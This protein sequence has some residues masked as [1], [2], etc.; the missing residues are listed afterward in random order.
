M[1]N[2]TYPGQVERICP[3]C[4]RIHFVWPSEIKRDAGHCCS[5]RCYHLSKVRPISEK[6][7]EKVKKIDTCWIWIG[8]KSEFGYGRLGNGNDKSGLQAHR[9]SWE[10]HHGPIPEGMAVCHK[11]DNPPCVNPNHLFLGTLKDNT[12][13]MLKKNRFPIKR[14]TAEE[15]QE[16][17][18][19]YAAGGISQSMLALMYGFSQTHISRIICNSP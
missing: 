15:I 17:R 11:C 1:L 18:T 9:V 14:I 2:R 5:P 13:D 3:I 16:I 4:Q 12:Q 19:R 10:L 7:W 6:F 8:A